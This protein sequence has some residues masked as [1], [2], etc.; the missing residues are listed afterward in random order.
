MC[1]SKRPAQTTTSTAPPPEVMEAYRRVMARAEPL[2]DTPYEA[3]GGERVAGFTPDQM[4]AF[5][6]VRDA[7]GTFQPYLD[8]ATGYATL[9]ASPIDAA[10]IQRYQ[11]PYQQQVIDATMADFNTQNARQLSE[12]RGN[13]AARGALGGNRVAVAESLAQEQQNRTQSPIIANLRSQGWNSALGAA[14]AD[15]AAA[16]QGAYTFG[17][18][19]GQ[20]LSS[21]LT[22]ANA[23]Y[24]M[25]ASQQAL[26][27]A[28][29]N[30]PY[31]NFQEQR[32]YPFQTT[33]WL[34]QIATGLGSNMGGTSTTS[35]PAPSAWNSIIGAAGTAAGA[36]MMSD[37]RAK[38]NVI[39]IGE[40][41]DGTPIYRFNY[42]GSDKTEV[43]VMAQDVE[44][45]DPDAVAR[46]PGGLRMVNYDRA[47]APSAMQG[48]FARGGAVGEIPG[49][50]FMSLMSGDEEGGSRFGGGLLSMMGDPGELRDN[51]FAWGLGGMAYK[52][53]KGKAEGGAVGMPGIA[54]GNGVMP[55]SG[56]F[57]PVLPMG[58]GAG[59][60]RSAPA[61]QSQSNDA[62][63]NALQNLASMYRRRPGAAPETLT[64]WETTVEPAM[65]GMAFGGVVPRGYDDGGV[66]EP[67][68]VMPPGF[69]FFH[70]NPL[71]YFGERSDLSSEPP[72]F[73]PSGRSF[74]APGAAVAHI[75]ERFT[76]GATTAIGGGAADAGSNLGAVVPF[77]DVDSADGVGRLPGVAAGQPGFSGPVVNP[78]PMQS[79]TGAANPSGADLNV[80]APARPNAP[81]GVAGLPP[82]PSP[83]NPVSR[84]NL[85]PSYRPPATL[86]SPIGPPQSAA[87]ATGGG[88]GGGSGQAPADSGMRNI[89]LALMMAGLRTMASPSPYLGVAIG[90]GGQTGVQ[91]YMQLDESQHR[92]RLSQ[93]QVNLQARRLEEQARHNRAGEGAGR[94]QILPGLPGQDA[95]R[96][97]TRTGEAAPVPVQIGSRTGGAGSGGA[98]ELRRNAWLA[99]NPN[100]Q[101]GALEYAAGR[102]AIP[103]AQMRATALNVAGREATALG[104]SGPRYTEHVD[105][106]ARELEAFLASPQAGAHPPAATPPPAAQPAAG[107]APGANAPPPD[108]RGLLGRILNSPQPPDA[109]AGAAPSAQAAPP[110]PS[111]IAGQTG[112]GQW[113]W[114]L[115]RQRW[116]HPTNPLT[117]DRNGNPVQ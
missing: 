89:G 36:Y 107:G 40:M 45:R 105:R 46:G 53:I 43:G 66:V 33:S 101:H 42:K 110:P 59:L 71:D 115:S 17:S 94:Y 27:Q 91:T 39:P 57:I 29:L 18:L 58:R 52:A 23:L 32:A 50:G 93:E 35:S 117:Y 15:R 69:D 102:R 86:G 9:G 74:A 19:G 96:F 111:A 61:A 56:G 4:Q 97:N 6:G 67:P 76:L 5:Q 20:A 25:G 99:I 77:L 60:P 44:R 1:G 85:A 68:Y 3:Y 84:M 13:A 88:A 31:Q 37:E 73:N 38:D 54:T 22:G 41:F 108:R 51:P 70:Q 95:I 92:R 10:S 83:P 113:G 55:Y 103:P 82:R 28:Q 80:V 62:A 72:L 63:G 64:G 116:V 24:G 87:P 12:V 104:L 109:P 75:P 26:D 2:A 81:T 114:S 30:V 16:G 79:F 47:T 90:E 49:S 106:R 34:S 112:P 78:R 21:S 14:Q 11:N 65:D 100:D 7:Q 48:E 98:W 8:Q